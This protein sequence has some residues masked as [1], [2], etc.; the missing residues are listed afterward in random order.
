M[1]VLALCRPLNVATVGLEATVGLGT[2]SC[3]PTQSICT[4][5]LG[6]VTALKRVWYSLKPRLLWAS[7]LVQLQTQA[8]VYSLRPGLLCTASDPGYCVQPQTQATVGLKPK[9]L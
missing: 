8:T 6:T 5:G 3:K 4:V 9:L 2:A 7:R 1:T